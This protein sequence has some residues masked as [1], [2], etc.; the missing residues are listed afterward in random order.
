MVA[1]IDVVERE[2]DAR[3]RGSAKELVLT[4]PKLTR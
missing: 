4:A 1:V 2:L 3:D